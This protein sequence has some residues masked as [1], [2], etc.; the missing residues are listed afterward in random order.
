MKKIIYAVLIIILSQIVFAGVT[1]PLPAELNLLPGES[2]RFKFQIQ[3][4]TSDYNLS[5]DYS[6][7]EKSPLN[8]EFDSDEIV[9][10]A[11]TIEDIYGTVDVPDELDYGTYEASFCISCEPTSKKA[12][13]SVKIDTCDLPI[14]VNVVS[15]REKENM[16]VPPKP[17]NRT[18]II[19]ITILVFLIITGMIY[20][21]SKLSKKP[22]KKK[23]K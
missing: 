7:E 13:A 3:T 10:P 1:N 4:V 8:I 5:C 12:G 15:G 22:K 14:K 9:V 20:F 23:K 16:Y 2:G 6:L 19:V 21:F 18:F 11:G 17:V